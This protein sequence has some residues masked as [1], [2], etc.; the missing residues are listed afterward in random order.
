M[1]VHVVGRLEAADETATVQR[2]HTTVLVPSGNPR[3]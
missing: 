1:G 2:N 3:S